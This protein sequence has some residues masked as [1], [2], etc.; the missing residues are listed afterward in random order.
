MDILTFEEALNK[1][2]S[3]TKRHLLLGNGFSIAC[4]HDIFT[5]TKLYEQAEQAGFSDSVRSAFAALD[6][7]DFEKVIKALNDSAKLV[8]AYEECENSDAVSTLMEGDA[9]EIKEVL[10]KTIA[11]S[12]PSKPTDISELEYQSCQEFLDNF[13][14]IYTLNYDLLLYW[15]KMNYGDPNQITSDDGFRTS[16]TDIATGITSEYVVWESGSSRS[17]NLFFLHGALH[18]FDAGVEV[19]KYTWN[20]TDIC[21]ID[22]TRQ[23]LQENRFPIFVAEGTSDE[24]LEKIRHNDFLAKAYRS[25]ES[26]GLCLFIYGHSLADNDEHFLR[27]I[28]RGK[29]KHVFVGLYGDENEPWNK[30]I[31][32]RARKLVENRTK[33]KLDLSFYDSESAQVW[34]R[35]NDL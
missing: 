19:Q 27:L 22:Q 25:F 4:R 5:Y 20:R 10:V 34:D 32:E 23:A 9:A 26:I 12:H 8:K 2:S 31:I 35:Y 6:T 24:K 13:T 17:Q 16:Q 14:N 18:I 7:T 3:Y 30:T 21:L 29:V 15:T 33:N 1:S 28:E 11:A